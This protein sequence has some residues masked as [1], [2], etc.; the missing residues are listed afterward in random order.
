MTALAWGG[1]A[2]GVLVCRVRRAHLRISTRRSPE[3]GKMNWSPSGS[4]TRGTGRRRCWTRWVVPLALAVLAGSCSPADLP[5][6]EAAAER[7]EAAEVIPVGARDT[8][9]PVIITERVL[10][11]SDDPAIWID[12]EHPERSLVLGTD[13]HRRDGGVYVFGLD[14]RIDHTR[15]VTG[16]RRPNNVDVAYG[17]QLGGRQVDIAVVT[18]REAMSL[19]VF[20][21]PAMQP[22]DG[23]GIRVFDGDKRRAPM[24]IALYRRPRD[25]AIFAMVSGKD[26]PRNGYLWQYR[27][28]DDGGGGVRG[29]KVRQFGRYSGR[30]EIEAIAVDAAL[31]Y[32][33]YSDETAGI[34]K[35]HADPEAGD[36]ELAFFGTA[37]FVRD[38]E[39]IAIYAREDGSGYI[40]VSDQQGGRLQVFAREGTS[41]NP[42]DHPALAVIPIVSRETDGIEVTAA[43]L[44]AGFPRGV[45]VTMSSDGTFHFYRWEDV[46]AR[47]R[48]AKI[49]SPSSA[50]P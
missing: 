9:R 46:Q 17:L 2:R 27:L 25:G 47:I 11:D 20:A 38:H 3:P 50:R 5:G 8:L 48:D 16:L 18:E 43:P 37:G 7:S 35:Y 14:G 32:V 44:G 36:Q 6:R 49:L 15:T 45:L 26:G 13:K 33:Y 29:V 40:L 41:A 22:I 31:G 24:G 39:G 34:R 10:D 4:Q 42:H 12:R 19:R 28:E 21:L 1:P 23:G 30:Q